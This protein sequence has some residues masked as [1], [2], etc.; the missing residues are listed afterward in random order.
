M[1][2]REHPPRR[3]PPSAV[4]KTDLT[5]ALNQFQQQKINSHCSSCSRPCCL[6]TDVVLDFTW[7]Q[8]TA[9]YEIKISQR[10]F[11]QG[12]QQRGEPTYIRKQEGLYYA[13][14]SPCPA[15]DTANK[16][17]NVYNTPLKPVN[18]SDFPLYFDGDEIIADSRC[19]A[20][21]LATL[22]TQ[23]RQTFPT[24]HFRHTQDRQF[25][26]INRIRVKKQR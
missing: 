10:Q 21:D 25:G 16:K 2:K 9:L 7:P 5:E 1:P 14:G 4:P 18:C 26:E 3:T 11:D 20:L 17:C 22:L 24:L 13:Y 15:Y 6:L 19:E 8:F 12:L 23:L